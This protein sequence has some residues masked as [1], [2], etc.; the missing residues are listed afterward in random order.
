MPVD[1][2]AQDARRYL[3]LPAATI[4][5]VFFIVPVIWFLM[6]SFSEPGWGL[7][8]YQVFFRS[9]VYARVAWNTLVISLSVTGACLLLGY[10]LAFTMAHVRPSVRKLLMFAI[11]IPLWTSLLVRSFAWMVL[12]QDNGIV[13]D[14]LIWTGVISEPLPL[15]YNRTG[16][17]LGMVQ[18]LLP[19][20]ILPLYSVMSRMDPG[21]LPAASTL[22]A[23]PAMAFMRVYV[24][25]SL[26]GILSGSSLVFVLCLGYYVTPA[27][28]GGRGDTMIGQLIV[29]QV[30]ELGNWGV[31]AALGF[32]L[33]VATIAISGV[34]FL[35]TRNS[36]RW[37]I[38]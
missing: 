4:V 38:R 13:N 15:I 7:Q 12:L 24:P 17:L 34:I 5:V 37:R 22:G 18:V 20:M 6:R 35:L 8:N 31:A 33:L 19:F 11:L 32:T 14:F 3:V 21:L 29:L 1:H 28:L 30:G 23:K 10:P 26:P 36:T 25:L 9:S 2:A 27:L 16:V